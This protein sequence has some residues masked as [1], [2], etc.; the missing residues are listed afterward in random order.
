MYGDWYNVVV[1]AVC[2]VGY[3]CGL[4]VHIPL[5]MWHP[6][7][8]MD[9]DVCGVCY[10][11][12]NVLYCV[13]RKDTTLISSAYRADIFKLLL[14]VHIVYTNFCNTMLF[15]RARVHQL[16]RTAMKIDTYT[17]V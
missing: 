3:V 12:Y 9:W 6:G 11:S 7:Y 10:I 15:Q 14:Y 8:A 5:G 1:F 2:A 17:Y 16:T 13:H 4:Y